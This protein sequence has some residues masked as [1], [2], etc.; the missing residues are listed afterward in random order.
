MFSRLL[1][2]ATRRMSAICR[3]VVY[4]PVKG[5]E[6]LTTRAVNVF[7]KE[8]YK[9]A[10][11]GSKNPLKVLAA[12]QKQFSALSA[13]QV[14]KY[15]AVAKANARKAAARRAVFKEVRINGFSLFFKQSYAKVAK[16][17]PAEGMAKCPAVAKQLAKQ[18]KALGKAGQAKYASEAAKLR[19]AAVEK[20]D[21]M[22][23]QYSA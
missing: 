8:N 4:T 17:V 18:W 23:A 10:A 11:K 16:G 5:G 22:I 15:T 21:R 12:L 14:A 6:K 19:N 3:K 9:N 7:Q 1:T 2:T 20:R 13:K